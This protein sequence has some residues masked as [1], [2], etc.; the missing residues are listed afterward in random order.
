MTQALVTDE[1]W[2]KLEPLL[3]KPKLKNRHVQYA[4][5]KP[6][7][8]RQIF[9]GIVFVLKT[10]VPWR[11]LP[12]T[13]AF[14]SGHTCRRY[15]LKW[16][17]AGI[18]TRLSKILLAELR[19]NGQLK[20]NYAAV[21]SSSVRA[22]GGGPKTG[23]NPT[24]RG[25]SGTKHHL[26]TDAKGTPLLVIVTAANRHDSTQLLPLVEELP[27][28]G[29]KVGHPLKK[30]KALYADRAYDSEPLRQKVKKNRDHAPS[31]QASHRA[32]KRSRKETA[33]R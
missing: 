22:P 21:D 13:A 5:R 20:L 18:W 25:K 10:G 2:K 24:D 27:S 6:K 15:L 29:G 23:R 28:I 14:P 4:G 11:A 33:R 1:L 31:S 30:P 19:K 32:R 12:A 8:L 7:D 17:K 16:H 9:N 3:P 26:I